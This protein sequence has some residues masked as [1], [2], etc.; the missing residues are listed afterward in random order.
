ME[1]QAEMFNRMCSVRSSEITI[2]EPECKDT[3]DDQPGAL[4]LFNN[5]LW[6][7]PGDDSGT[8]KRDYGVN[9]YNSAYDK[10]EDLVKDCNL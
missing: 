4:G 3:N 1:M 10:S 9:I 8:S 5:K 7:N 6:K 2:D